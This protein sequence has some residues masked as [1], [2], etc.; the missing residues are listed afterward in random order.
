MAECVAEDIVHIG[1]AALQVFPQNEIALRADE[2]A[3]AG[4]AFG[5]FPFLV[6]QRLDAG[7]E[8]GDPGN[9]A[10]RP[11]GGAA[12]GF[13]PEQQ[14]GGKAE[15]INRCLFEGEQGHKGQIP[16]RGRENCPSI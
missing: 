16:K 8:I 2:I 10:L 14:N 4:F 5:D 6:A 11:R 15:E 13:E 3:V 9:M 7:F 12:P 1:E